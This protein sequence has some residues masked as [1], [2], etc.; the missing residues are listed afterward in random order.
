M[1]S[2]K[3]VSFQEDDAVAGLGSSDEEKNDQGEQT[4]TPRVTAG[5]QLSTTRTTNACQGDTRGG[6]RGCGR[7]QGR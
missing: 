6:G 4:S 3:K 2:R 1:A 7:G 5:A